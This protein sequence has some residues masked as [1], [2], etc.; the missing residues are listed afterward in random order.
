MSHNSIY[1]TFTGEQISEI[2]SASDGP[3]Q[4]LYALLAG[5]GMRIGEAFGSGTERHLRKQTLRHRAHAIRQFHEQ[6]G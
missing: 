2:L 6:I 4:I 3:A 1:P 5:T